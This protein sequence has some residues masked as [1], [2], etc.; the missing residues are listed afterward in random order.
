MGL[1]WISL[2]VAILLI[3]CSL[4]SAGRM[5]IGIILGDPN[6]ISLKFWQSRRSAIDLAVAWDFDDYFHIHGD[7]LY[8]FPIQMEGVS[9][10]SLFWYLGIGA[11][12][13]FR[14]GEGDNNTTFGVRGVGGIDFLPGGVPIDI[15]AEIAP[16]MNVSEGTDVDLNGGVGIRYNFNL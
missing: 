5:G 10:S 16:V 7:Y 15:F 12:M 4:L 13:K 14:T 6:G 2:V 9:R 11:R 3:F 8:H 1:K